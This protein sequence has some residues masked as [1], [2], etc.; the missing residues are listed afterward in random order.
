MEV[1]E[2]FARV[3]PFHISKDIIEKCGNGTGN[4]GI[5]RRTQTVLAE[6]TS[7]TNLNSLEGVIKGISSH[8]L[9]RGCKDIK[10]GNSFSGA[11]IKFPNYLDLIGKGN[12]LGIQAKIWQDDEILKL[13]PLT[14][15]NYI[16]RSI[17]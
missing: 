2:I 4:C 5:F 9:F 17:F 10:F 3:T 6:V 1:K 8:F 7:E 15:N 13:A 12:L 16:I 11:E 14:L